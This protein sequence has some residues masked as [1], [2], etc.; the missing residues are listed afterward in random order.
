MQVCLLMPWKG[1]T[2]W[3]SFVMSNCDVV[4]FQ[5]VNWVRCGLIVS[6]PDLCPLSYFV[7]TIKVLSIVNT[8]QM[9]GIGCC[10][11]LKA[12]AQLNI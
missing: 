2:S 6:I 5:L 11:P 12:T 9:K 7:F 3:L 10:G 4:T 8:M 1:L